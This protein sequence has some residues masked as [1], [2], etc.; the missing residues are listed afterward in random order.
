[1]G[2]V[3]PISYLA[4]TLHP[5]KAKFRAMALLRAYFDESGIDA[6]SKVVAISGLIAKEGSWTD[7]EERWEN[8]VDEYAHLGLSVFHMVD[9]IHQTREFALIDTPSRNYVLTQLS[10]IL[11]DAN[12]T[13]IFSA[14]IKDHWDSEVKSP[15]FLDKFPEPFFLCFEDIMLQ[16][17]EWSFKNA[18]QEYVV[19]I[20][21]NQQEYNSKMDRI[22][23][24]RCQ[25]PWYSNIISPISFN[26][27]ENLIPLQAA[28]FVAYSMREDIQDREFGTGLGIT[29]KAFHTATDG[30]FKI[31]HWFDGNGL[32]RVIRN[33]LEAGEIYPLN[34]YPKSAQVPFRGIK[35]CRACKDEKLQRT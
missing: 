3:I 29:S 5:R 31:G 9:F 7:L 34:P 11:R 35:K 4:R 32:N 33:Y 12:V 19:P 20:F 16:L 21:A 30:R 10:E 25:F 6:N 1:M 8:V 26:T 13:P 15:A 27:P 17:W 28:D 18:K 24:D 23:R 2:K 22:D 14:V